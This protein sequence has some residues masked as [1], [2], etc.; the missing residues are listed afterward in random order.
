MVFCHGNCKVTK[1]PIATD[2]EKYSKKY[3]CLLYYKPISPPTHLFS[4]SAG[5]RSRNLCILDKSSTNELYF[6]L[7][8]F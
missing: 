8:G 2:L 4:S 6:Q 3:V 5:D 1:A 7:Q